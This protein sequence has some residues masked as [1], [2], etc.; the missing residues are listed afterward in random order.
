MIDSDVHLR[1][2]ARG[3]ILVGLVALAGREEGRK[4]SQQDLVTMHAGD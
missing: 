3:V 4:S 2:E 1:S